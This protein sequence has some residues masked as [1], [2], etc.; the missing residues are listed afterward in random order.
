MFRNI[1]SFYGEEL[2]A[3]RLTPQA[4]GP[5]LVG[6]PR[7]LGPYIRN[8]PPYWRQFF[9]PQRE[10][11]PCRGDRTYLLQKFQIHMSHYIYINLYYIIKIY[12]NISDKLEMAEESGRFQGEPAGAGAVNR[13]I[14]TLD[15][16]CACVTI[17]QN[18]HS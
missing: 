16:K 14:S 1:A 18:T 6:C 11:A 2:S 13:T 8:Y 3:P 5:L 10:V 17:C 15:L 9:R 7:L 12:I 4:G